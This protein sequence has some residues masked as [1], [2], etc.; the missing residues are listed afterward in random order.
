M[1]P[2]RIVFRIFDD[3]RSYRVI[4]DVLERH[5]VLPKTVYHLTL[6]TVAP[7]VTMTLDQS[8]IPDRKRPEKPL[9]DRRQVLPP[10]RSDHNVYMIAH[11]TNGGD[12]K[13][14]PIPRLLECSD[15][16]RYC[17]FILEDKLTPVDASYDVICAVFNFD[18]RT[19]HTLLYSPEQNHDCQFL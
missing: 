7:D 6:E 2:V 5:R 10:T 19:S 11:N 12:T 14:I 3:T 13:P 18:S 15:K 16:Q 9:H 4:C 17:L 1:A 8:V